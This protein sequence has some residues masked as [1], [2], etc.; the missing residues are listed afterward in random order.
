MKFL[1][2][3]WPSPDAP[4]TLPSSADFAAQIDW[5]RKLIAEGTIETT[6]HGKGRAVFIFE[7]PSEQALNRMLADIPLSDRMARSIEP[8]SDFFTHAN[9]VI[10]HLR[11]AETSGGERKP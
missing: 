3:T 1:V 10:D 6:Y 11:R 9:G 4:K 5:V 8:L 2:F 7:A